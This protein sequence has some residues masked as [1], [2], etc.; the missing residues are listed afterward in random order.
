MCSI[1][2]VLSDVSGLFLVITAVTALLL[3]PTCLKR[4]HA[5]GLASH[6]S[7]LARSIMQTAWLAG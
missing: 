4:L 1:A 3:C 2:V 7:Q 5:A 6:M